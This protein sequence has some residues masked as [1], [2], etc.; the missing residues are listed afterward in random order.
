[1][2][3][4]NGYQGVELGE[5]GPR[6]RP[7]FPKDFF[8]KNYDGF[9]GPTLQIGGPVN[10]W[11]EP[12]STP[13]DVAG[14]G[15][16]VTGLVLG[17]PPFISQLATLVA[18]G[19]DGATLLK[20]AEVN[21]GNGQE[22]LLPGSSREL[23]TALG[24]SGFRVVNIS[25]E[26]QDDAS[27]S[28]QTDFKVIF[29]IPTGPQKL[30]VVAAGNDGEPV[31][32]RYPAAFGGLNRDNVITVGATRPDGSLA[33]FSNWG[34]LVDIAAP[35]CAL[36]SSIDENYRLAPMSGT[37]QAA[38]QVSF[39]A[40]LLHTLGNLPAPDIKT[41]L[42]ISGD[43]LVSP[44]PAEKDGRRDPQTIASRSALNLERALYLYDDYLMLNDGRVFL[45]E[46]KDVSGLS[47]KTGAVRTPYTQHDLLAFKRDNAT[48]G[49]VFTTGTNSSL[50]GSCPW[51]RTGKA[52][53]AFAPVNRVTDAGPGPLGPGDP[54]LIKDLDL[55]GVQYLVVR[56]SLKVV[57]G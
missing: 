19:D 55:A 42:L 48:G 41:R 36:A 8:A 54:A 56:R 6:F 53:I 25:L 7:K 44:S 23:R 9:V 26:Y 12:P 37:S 20:V 39:A 14:H 43:L 10:P 15:T 30:F 22:A 38:P 18:D 34:N 49:W 1:M 50:A 13:N 4:D 27:E 17:G 40:A 47:C 35:G 2:V 5:N 28:V 29:T 51:D 45:G 52:K 3:V 11:I 57:G 32:A 33:G 16:H 21:V 46:L 24:L 31:S